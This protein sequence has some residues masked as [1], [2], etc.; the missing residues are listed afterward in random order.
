M[1]TQT[2]LSLPIHTLAPIVCCSSL[3]SFISISRPLFR[4]CELFP[5]MDPH[6]YQCSR[7]TTSVEVETVFMRAVKRQAGF[8]ELR[9]PI[10]CGE[11]KHTCEHIDICFVHTYI[12][13]HTVY[14][15]SI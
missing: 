15:A 3:L 5:S 1:Y 9:I 13:I 8:N 12:Y 4:D 14:S 11:G 2:T 6:F 7:R 10:S